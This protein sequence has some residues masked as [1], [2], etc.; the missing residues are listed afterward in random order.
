MKFTLQLVRHG[1]TDAVTQMIYCGKTDLPLNQE[2]IDELQEKIARG[3]YL[4]AERYYTSGLKRAEETLLLIAPDVSYK[5]IPELQEYNFGIFELHRHEDL[6]QTEE[7]RTWIEDTTGDYMVPQGESLNGF[8][9]RVDHGFAL[10]FED[11]LQNGAKSVLVTSHGGVIA[12]FI[13]KFMMRRCKCTMRC[14]NMVA[15]IGQ[16]SSMTAKKLIL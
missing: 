12:R 15:D 2:G 6:M 14:Q 16:K 5:I 1:K 3:I 9:E 10:L 4:P 8:H 11:I 13:T 7:Y